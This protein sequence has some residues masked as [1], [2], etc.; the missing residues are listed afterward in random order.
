VV[1]LRSAQLAQLAPR[2]AYVAVVLVATATPFELRFEAT[3]I[4]A[5]LGRAFSLGYSPTALVDAAQNMA[6]FA[7]WGALWIATGHSRPGERALLAPTL[8]GFVLS[9]G[10]ETMQLLLP[11]RTTSVQ[12]VVTN[13]VGALIGA[14][15][16]ASFVNVAI[17]LRE[18][19]SYFGVPALAFAGSYVAAAL[20]QAV[21][22]SA[23]PTV[24]SAARG[25]P[26]TRLFNGLA[27][28]DPGSFITLP[29]MEVV[30]FFPAGLF[31]LVVLAEVG[32]PHRL[33]ARYVAVAGLVLALATELM[34]GTLGF[35]IEAGPVFM[36]ALGVFLGALAAAKWLGPFSRQVRGRWRPLLLAAVYALGIAIWAWRPFIFETE[37]VWLRL[38][39]SASRLIPLQG[40]SWRAGLVGVG[41]VGESFFLFLPVGALLAVWPLRRR[42]WLWGWLPGFYLAALAELGQIAVIDRFFDVT[43]LL[44]E[45]AAVA[46]G[47]AIIRQAGY[48]VHGAMLPKV[49]ARR[50]RGVT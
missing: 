32:M 6:L 12:D 41:E 28:F 30:L 36:R 37:P 14:A 11:A 25:G 13:T 18:R 16:V 23:H 35:P 46:I 43:D 20:F 40:G 9:L 39:L 19:R 22:G 44:V 15:F 10:V 26:F 17:A 42:G 50:A 27:A 38:Q 7:G 47:W 21:L 33:A 24:L 5:R 4:M 34:R 3:E 45:A 48:P 2:L 29:V 1:N 31:A 49:G 8:T